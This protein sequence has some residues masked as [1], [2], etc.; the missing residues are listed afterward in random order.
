M[1]E[2]EDMQQIGGV[3]TGKRVS[4]N[5]ALP[6]TITVN[7]SEYAKSQPSPSTASATGSVGRPASMSSLGPVMAPPSSTSI[8]HAPELPKRQAYGRTMSGA[9][10]KLSKIEQP[11]G[12]SGDCP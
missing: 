8:K 3:A 9:S 1:R 5:M 6:Q 10:L 12:S 7:L 4:S 11:D 2:K